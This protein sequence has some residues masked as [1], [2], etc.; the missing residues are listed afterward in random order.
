MSSESKEFIGLISKAS[1][2]AC[3]AVPMLLVADKE[4]G[5]EVVRRRYSP[6]EIGQA[7]Q[8]LRET[9]VPREAA[10][11]YNSLIRSWETAG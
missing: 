9:P 3:A 4:D 11:W 5:H 6:D 7:L 1:P 8:L 10:E 2:A